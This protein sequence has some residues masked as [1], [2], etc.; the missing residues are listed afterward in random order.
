[1]KSLLAAAFFLVTLAPEAWATAQFEE[2]LRIDGRVWKMQSTPLEAVLKRLPQRPP[3]F[4]S[5]GSALWRGYRGTWELRCGRLWLVSLHRLGREGPDGSPWRPVPLSVVFPGQR[6][7]ILATWHSGVLRIPQGRMVQYVHMGFGSVYEKTLEFRVVHGVVHS[8]RR[9]D[10]RAAALRSRQ[11]L[12]WS[13]LG[14]PEAAGK[15]WVDARRIGEEGFAKRVGPRFRPRGVYLQ[16]QEGRR[17]ALWMPETRATE[18]QVL[19]HRGVAEVKSSRTWP[20]VEVDVTLAS[21]TGEILLD[22]HSLRELPGGSTIHHPT[23]QAAVPDLPAPEPRDVWDWLATTDTLADVAMCGCR[24]GASVQLWGI[25]DRTGPVPLLQGIEVARS[26]V[27]GGTRALAVGVLQQWVITAR[28]L[29]CSP[30]RYRA[31][32]GRGPGTY[33]RLVDP[34]TGALA[35]PRDPPAD[36]A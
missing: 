33:W 24:L 1:M 14:V 10:W 13:A 15:P 35:I 25:L 19:S 12:I 23:F 22:V 27:G 8:T 18:E 3:V 2:H 9:T 28:M 36:D 26:R 34:L 6:G 16:P 20:H 17:A 5:Q 4:A 21:R 31:F 7:P 29:H 30:R 11:D 32:R